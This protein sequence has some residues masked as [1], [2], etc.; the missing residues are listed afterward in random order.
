VDVTEAPAKIVKSQSPVKALPATLQ[1]VKTSDDVT[2]DDVTLKRASYAAPS[3]AD[4]S[5]HVRLQSG[6]TICMVEDARSLARQRRNLAQKNPHNG[7]H[8]QVKMR[9]RSTTF[10]GGLTVTSQSHDRR[11]VPTFPFNLNGNNSHQG[12]RG[13]AGGFP[14]DQYHHANEMNYPIS[15]QDLSASLA[16]LAKASESGTSDRELMPPPDSKFSTMSAATGRRMSNMRST[17]S[18]DLVNGGKSDKKNHTGSLWSLNFSGKKPSNLGHPTSFNQPR[19]PSIKERLKGA[20]S[21]QN[22]RRA[23]SMDKVTEEDSHYSNR[24]PTS[25]PSGYN[26]AF[27]Q[28]RLKKSPS[29]ASMISSTVR[30]RKRKSRMRQVRNTIAIDTFNLEN[31]AE[32]E[33]LTTSVRH[34]SEISRPNYFRPIGRVVSINAVEGTALVEISKPPSGPFGFYLDQHPHSQTFYISSL[35]DGYPEKMYSGLMRT[36]DEVLEVNGISLEGLSLDAVNDIILDSGSVRL[37]VKPAK[38]QTV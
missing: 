36:G 26:N 2:I 29:I 6:N 20:F 18:G 10:D 32:K 35:N 31:I 25:P 33:R 34:T 9:I 38:V 15:E 12:R 3:R 4:Y 16:N 28:G 27:E 17:T 30:M 37:K 24:S 1:R 19:R 8:H 13:V 11:S 5:K 23:I 22:I 21:F 14:H 7:N